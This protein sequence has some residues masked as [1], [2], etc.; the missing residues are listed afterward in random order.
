M[1]RFLI[2]AAVYSVQLQSSSC[3]TGNESTQSCVPGSCLDRAQQCI[4]EWKQHPA[5]HYVCYCAFP[6]APLPTMPPSTWA[7]SI[8]AA[9]NVSNVGAAHGDTDS[10][11]A[12]RIAVAGELKAA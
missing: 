3:C 5:R 8:L 6:T 1:A 7:P 10:M 2:L 9:T 4:G 11:L 12:T